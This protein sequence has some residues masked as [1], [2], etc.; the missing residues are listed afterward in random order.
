V[1][2][3]DCVIGASMD[4]AILCLRETIGG[5][6]VVWR[7]RI[8][9][10]PVYADLVYAD[11]R[12]L[13]SASDLQLYCLDAVS[14]ALVWRQRMLEHAPI[15][16]REIRS[17]EMTGGG[18]YQSKPTAAEGKV[19]VGTPARF[20]FALDHVTGREVWRF[21]MGGAVSGAPAY[22]DGRVFIGQQGG[23]EDFYGLDAGS[24][25]PIWRQALAWIWSSAN[26]DRGRVFVPGVDGYLSCLDAATGHILWR[27]RTGRASHP[28]PPVDGDRVF[29]GS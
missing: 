2:V 10:H 8:G 16:G 9:E 26:V 29:F 18:F 11:G 17:D 27:Y 25:L 12:L 22:A 3:G 23:E 6:Q 15:G 28:E 4:G 24:G 14:G 5:P 13:V 1:V 7:T 20:V 19:F 21:E